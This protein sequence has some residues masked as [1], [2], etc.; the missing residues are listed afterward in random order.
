LSLG[1]IDRRALQALSVRQRKLVSRHDIVSDAAQSKEVHL[2]TAGFAY[3][4]K[5]LRNGSRQIMGF[6]VPGDLCDLG[7]W[8]LGRIDH[9][10]SALGNCEVAVIPHR[11][12]FDLVEKDAR[13][14]LGV[15]RETM[16]DAAICRE[17]VTNL[18]RRPAY[19][20]LAHLFCE[21]WY[22]LHAVGL[23]LDHAYD[24]PV[25]QSELG[26][27]LGLSIVHVNRT[28]RDMRTTGLI[29][30]Q[31]TRIKLLDWPRLKEAAEFDP[32]YLQA[33]HV[34]EDRASPHESRP[35]LDD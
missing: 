7:T 3:R 14:T 35:D 33:H 17:W 4:Y 27:A 9:G 28:L 1:E 15:W 25:T 23:T 26:D 16:I 18:G 22:R 2:L 21:I 34:L 24:F 10:I 30:P 20:R 5:E 8:L 32:T 6:L 29:S 11:R 13:L 19:A 31:S 12:L